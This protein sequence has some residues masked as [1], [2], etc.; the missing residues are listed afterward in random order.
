MLVLVS[1]TSHTAMATTLPDPA[2]D[3]VLVPS[4]VTPGPSESIVLAGGCF[5]GM[6]AVFQHVKGVTKVIA[7][8]AGG[9]ADTAH[10]EMVSTGTTGHAEAVHVTF[11]PSQ[12]TLGQILKIYFS[13]AHDPTELN[14]QGPDHGTQYRSAVFYANAGQ[15]KIV[16]TYIQQLNGARV[17]SHPVVTQPEPLNAFYPAEDYHQDYARLHPYNP[18]I[19]INDRPKVTEL[20]KTL[21]SFFV[22]TGRGQ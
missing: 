4:D 17:F 3:A 10:Y 22:D 16:E 19:L 15:K 6:Q 8:Y 18:Y 12:I 1:A 9:K 21:P 14:S 20:E 7:G 13:V 11:D 5:W 2:L